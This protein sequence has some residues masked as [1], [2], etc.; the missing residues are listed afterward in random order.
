MFIERTDAEAPI[1]WPPHAKNGLIGKVPDTGKD[2]RQE[3]QGV[4]EVEM[5]GWHHRFNEHEF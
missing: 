3:E 5:V 1:F 4:K 2:G